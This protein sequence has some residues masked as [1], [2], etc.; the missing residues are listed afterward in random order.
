MFHRCLNGV[1]VCQGENMVL[2]VIMRERHSSC[3]HRL[4]EQ[5]VD[6]HYIM[7]VVDFRFPVGVNQFLANALQKKVNLN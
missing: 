1:S 2:G 5:A 7:I 6:M 3:V 4:H